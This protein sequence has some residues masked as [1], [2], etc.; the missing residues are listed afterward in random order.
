MLTEARAVG[1]VEVVVE[2]GMVFTVGAVGA[3]V[4]K[5][6]P[7]TEVLLAWPGPRVVAPS[8]P[9]LLWPAAVHGG[10][11]AE[12][13]SGKPGESLVAYSKGK[14]NQFCELVPNN[15]TFEVKGN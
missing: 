11:N 10:N 15:L 4:G 12:F 5:V 3:L 6:P 1:V 13:S 7:F 9:P 8:W 2:V 14:K